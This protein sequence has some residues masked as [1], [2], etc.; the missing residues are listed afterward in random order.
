MKCK[1]KATAF[2]G[3]EIEP[4]VEI[5]VDAETKNKLLPLNIY[6][7]L[8]E[9]LKKDLKI[10][11]VEF[12]IVS[13]DLEKLQNAQIRIDGEYFVKTCYAGLLKF[14]SNRD[15]GIKDQNLIRA[16]EMYDSK[17]FDEAKEQV[18][19]IEPNSLSKYD[20]ETYVLL[21]FK[22]YE[23]SDILFEQYKV[24]LAESP[25]KIRELYFAYIKYLE[26][27]RDAQKPQII[28]SEFEVHYPISELDTD[29]ATVYYYLK[30]RANYARGEFLLALKNLAQAK[31][32][33]SLT[34]IRLLASIYNTAANC[35]TDNLFFDEALSL[36][37][38][39]LRIRRKLKLPEEAETLSLIG[40]IYFKRNNTRKS[41]EYY[42][43]AEEKFVHKEARIYNYLTKVSITIGYAAKA[44]EYLAEAKQYE[45][46]KGFLTVIEMYYALKCKKFEKVEELF[47]LFFVLP[48]KRKKLDKFVLGWGYTFMALVYFE[49]K[50]FQKALTA[51]YRSVD[52]FI[53][54]KYILEAYY[55]SLYPFLYPVPRKEMDVYETL[56]ESSGL[57]GDFS[58]YVTKHAL[59]VD[60]YHDIFELDS[61]SKYILLKDFSSLEMFD[62][63]TKKAVE[64]FMGKYQLF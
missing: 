15:P 37:E 8:Q 63:H 4:M 40:G 27:I 59:I 49:Q 56:M 3:V 23:K 18:E 54:D 60:M 9:K 55:V 7:N 24:I 5:Y 33:C 64:E 16:K 48:E 41:Y 1:I 42:K 22:L 46:R 25:R 11:S 43:K 26:D 17:L 12:N 51:L 52:N 38:K 58:E 34:N 47:K 14:F 53:S 29:E 35:F 20:Y 45:D 31:K 21:R 30:G 19:Y 61:E 57:K 6:S 39:A 44:K 50:E 28:L 62:N 13:K 36:A 2:N 32:L 10:E